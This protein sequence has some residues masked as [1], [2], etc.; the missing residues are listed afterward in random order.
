MFACVRDTSSGDDPYILN[1]N[2]CDYSR[3]CVF[4]HASVCASVSAF[5]FVLLYLCN[6]L[7]G[8]QVLCLCAQLLV[9]CVRPW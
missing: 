5:V 8:C 7:R 2:L 6:D 9:W 3:V 4:A 1:S